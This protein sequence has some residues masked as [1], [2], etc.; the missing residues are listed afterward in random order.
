MYRLPTKLTRS[1]TA[2]TLSFETEGLHK[3]RPQFTVLTETIVGPACAHICQRFNSHNAYIN[4][5]RQTNNSS[6]S[7]VSSYVLYRETIFC[8]EPEQNGN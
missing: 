7:Q 5:V 6:R 4:D 8:Q 3:L 1:V 2:L